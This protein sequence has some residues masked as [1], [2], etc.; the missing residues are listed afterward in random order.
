M[1]SGDLSVSIASGVPR[2]PG[3]HVAELEVRS[4]GHGILQRLDIFARPD[5]QMSLGERA[6][7][8]GLV[9][10][11]N[12][13][14]AIEIGT[15]EG[16]SLESIATESVEVHSID[17]T[18]EFLVRRPANARFHKGDSRV[19]LPRLLTAFAD[20]GHNVDFALVDGDHS[21]EGVRADLQALLDSPAVGRTL[22][23]VH[24]S[25]NPDVRSGIESA[26]L[27]DNPKVV[28]LDLDFVPGRLGKLGAFADQLLGGFALVMV[29]DGLGSD[30]RRGVDLGFWS[31]N[32]T[33][34]LFHDGYE[35]MRRG[36]RLVGAPEAASTSAE[37]ARLRLDRENLGREQLQRELDA[38]RSSRSW[39]LTAPLRDFRARLRRVNPRRGG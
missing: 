19:V 13:R 10:Q 4:L 22:I 30:H 25:F 20:E 14:L 29:D 35:V 1:S 11:L 38:L 31:M 21:T 12:P 24:D 16:G 32:P 37:P 7:L 28:G 27:V 33:P 9:A 26:D 15:A 17:L 8:V 34:I 5:W 23:L 18:D 39:R 6:A 36:G 3:S 2:L